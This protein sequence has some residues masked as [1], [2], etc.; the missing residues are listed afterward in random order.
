MHADSSVPSPERERLLRIAP[1]LQHPQ[2]IRAIFFDVGFTLLRPHPSMIEVVQR[3][4]GRM[5]VAIALE[6][7]QDR[8]PVANQLFSGSHHATEA[9]WA[10]NE[11]INAFWDEYFTALLTPFF[12]DG[13]QLRHCVAAT[14]REFERAVTWQPFPD[15]I[16]ALER[17]RG[18]YT[19]GIVSDWGIG[20]GPILQGH[21]LHHYFAFGVVSATSRRA[22]PDPAL[23]VEALRRGDA[24][25]DY[26]LYV[27]DTY[28]QD[29]L[30]ARSVG[31]H[32]VLIDRRA[33]LD[34]LE[35]DCPVIHTLDDL[36]GLLGMGS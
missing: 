1:W 27:G 14:L 29:I 21:D 16:P 31:I 18:R 6:A 4:A 34:P 13:E 20:L 11:A 8:T 10:D 19:L 25:G 9:T 7:L 30:G 12:A 33:R 17:L 36:L 2:A 35:V 28:V 24:L 32:P 3:V 23:F 5:G 15:V 26:T 22:K